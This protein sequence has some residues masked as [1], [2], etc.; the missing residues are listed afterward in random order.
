MFKLLGSDI[1]KNGSTLQKIET[2][3]M[4]QGGQM[5]ALL[6]DHGILLGKVCN[7]QNHAIPKYR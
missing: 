6:P 1:I 3:D 7:Q 2:L 5:G 4:G